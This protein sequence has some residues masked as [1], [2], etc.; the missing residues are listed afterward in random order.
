MGLVSSKSYEKL[1]FAPT[2]VQRLLSLCFVTKPLPCS[3][4]SLFSVLKWRRLQL[5]SVLKWRRLRRWEALFGGGFFGAI[6]AVMV[7][8]DCMGVK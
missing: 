1:E 8:G 3:V 6:F 7:L 2:S 5:F 4:F